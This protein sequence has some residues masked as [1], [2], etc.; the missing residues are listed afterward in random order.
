MKE[1]GDKYAHALELERRGQ[2]WQAQKLFYRAFRGG[3]GTAKNKL[4]EFLQ[5]LRPENACDV[6]ISYRRE[7]GL[8]FSHL[9]YLELKC[10]GYNVFFDYNSLRSGKFDEEIL[11]AIKTCKFVVSVVTD[12]CLDRCRD[13][14]DWV[15]KELSYAFAN[16]KTVLAVKR[17]NSMTSFPVD[18]PNDIVQLQ[19][20]PM[21]TWDPDDVSALDSLDREYFKACGNDLDAALKNGGIDSSTRGIVGDYAHPD[22][23]FDHCVF[24]VF[25]EM[26]RK[27]LAGGTNRRFLEERDEMNV[28]SFFGED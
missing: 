14:S 8:D 16:K 17:I 1:H 9:I 24:R 27:E 4:D 12:G 22:E 21:L 13:E 23:G 10:R 20:V 7:G 18:L 15:R 11:N 2:F 6:F 3:D 25:V 19:S 5:R 28:S 26:I